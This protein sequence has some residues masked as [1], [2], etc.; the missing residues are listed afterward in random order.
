MS[1]SKDKMRADI[2]EALEIAPEEITDEANLFDLGLDS[3]RLMSLVM[4][5]QDEGEEGD[6]SEIWEHQTFG[7]WW[8]VVAA[9]RAGA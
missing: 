7:A 4:T 6:L 3:M 2:A 9:Q 1:L 8:G 5:W